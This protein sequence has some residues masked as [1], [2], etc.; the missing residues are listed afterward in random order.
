MVEKP[1]AKLNVLFKK[2]AEKG[3][4][5]FYDSPLFNSIKFDDVKWDQL[6]IFRVLSRFANIDFEKINDDL[7][8][9]AYESHIPERERKD[10]GQ[11]YTPQFIVEYLIE[12]L[13][14]TSKSQ[15]LDPACGSG[16]F[17]TRVLDKLTRETNI[18]PSQAIE[19]NLYGIDINPF[20]NQLTTMNL[21][22]KT[23]DYDTK[24]EQINILSADA[25]I[26]ETINQEELFS[27]LEFSSEA[28]KNVRE[29]NHFFDSGHKKFDAVI[30]NPPYRCFGLKSNKA[31]K[32]QY[33]NYLKNRWL[34][35]A[36]Y[37][38]T[39]YPLFIERSIELLKKN[40]ILAFILPDSF[41][42]GR[43]FSKI[44]KYILETCK[45]QEI[46][47]CREDFWEGDVGFPTLLVLQKESNNIKRKNNQITAKLAD[48]QSHIKANK[49]KKYKFPQHTFQ[50]ISRNRFELYFDKYSRE[51]VETMRSKSDVSLKE[52][53]S[54]YSGAIAARGCNKQ[55]II[56]DKKSNSFFQKGLLAGTEIIPYK[57][58]Y[59]NGWIKIDSKALRSGYDP[60]VMERP[61]I[62][63]RQT[64]DTL[65]AA[66]DRR[67]L[68]HLNIIHSFYSKEN[69]APFEWIALIMNSS[70][71]NR[72]YHIASMEFGR[73]MAQTDIDQI[74]NLPFVEPS[75]KTIEKAKELYKILSSSANGTANYKNA[76]KRAE[77]MV[78]NEYGINKELK[79]TAI[80]TIES[81]QL[82]SVSRIKKVIKKSYKKRS[83]ISKKKRKKIN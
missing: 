62:L 4:S 67:K 64:G 56:S 46:V 47:L 42:A 60:E 10:L 2:S 36:E 65:I 51:L 74:E 25:L 63:V 22:L 66:V 77:T 35:S 3:F 13:D 1:S 24:P 50:I 44:R 75:S 78:A 8:G 9:K 15:I 54:G 70:I 29:L 19:N 7:I 12:Q 71:M 69:S 14:L 61:K 53:M 38:I 58:Q 40:G 49:F 72:F 21:L 30:G 39:Y 6:V 37:K 33:D 55:D 59:N 43:Y 20:A 68:Y 80:Y 23:L 52:V 27:S 11:F 26:D 81:R 57:V 76:K 45:I 31:M 18:T 73:A 34:N 16:A 17:L 5:Q 28:K 82:A 83:Q 48:T 79:E 41:L 32:K